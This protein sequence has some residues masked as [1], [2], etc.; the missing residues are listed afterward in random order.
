MK[1]YILHRYMAPLGIGVVCAILVLVFRNLYVISSLFAVPA[2]GGLCAALL[3]II[4]DNAMHERELI[5][6]E[7]Q[8]AFTMG[9]ASHMSILVFDKHITFCEEY[10]GSLHDIIQS[11]FEKGPNPG[12]LENAATLARIRKKHTLWIPDDVNRE[13]IE[14]EDKLYT[15][16]TKEAFIHAT[17][18][19]NHCREKR[20]AE[21]ESSFEIFDQ[22]L[23]LD[24]SKNASSAIA[25]AIALVKKILG[26][27]ELYELRKKMTSV[28]LKRI[29][30]H[31]R[32]I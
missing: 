1:Q 25:N 29:I 13:L 10:I 18:G 27:S 7:S 20:N 28:A 5:R 31:E 19:A 9:G 22:I 3:Q 17:I 6:V 32:T 23:G 30:Q 15:L 26:V 12:A 4:R 24:K 21:I 14:F 2:I 11:L 8:G 16:G